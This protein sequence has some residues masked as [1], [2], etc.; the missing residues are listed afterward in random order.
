MRRFAAHRS[1]SPVLLELES[2]DCGGKKRTGDVRQGKGY[3][4]VP[5]NC[6]Q[7][8][9]PRA[10]TRVGEWQALVAEPD[11]PQKLPKRDSSRYYKDESSPLP[12]LSAA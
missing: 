1:V 10:R 2:A 3:R 4:L 9:G 6:F 5:L 7:G 12:H 11:R 8:C